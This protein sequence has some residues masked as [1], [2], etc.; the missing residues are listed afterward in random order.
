MD[1][2]VRAATSGDLRFDIDG[3]LAGYLAAAAAFGAVLARDA[4]AVV[5]AHTTDIPI[6]INGE[7]NIDF[8]GDGQVDFQIDHDRYNLGGTDLDYLQIDKN[9]AS[10]AED[11]LPE[12]FNWTFPKIPHPDYNEN[13]Q[14]DAADYTKW[15]NNLGVVYDPNDS[16]QSAAH[17]EDGNGNGVIDEGD[18][19]LWKDAFGSDPNYDHQYMIP[20]GCPTGNGCYPA[21]LT[22][23]STIGPGVSGSQWDFSESTNAF[24]SG[25][26]LRANRL[27]DEDAGQIDDAIGGGSTPAGDSPHFTG[28]AGA[29]RF[30]GVRIDLNDA[31]QPGNL[32]PTENGSPFK[33]W[34]GWIGVQITNEAD[35]TG[36]ITGYAYESIVGVGITAG[37]TGAGAGSGAAV[38][39]PS[40][41]FLGVIGGIFML[42]AFLAR[43]LLGGDKK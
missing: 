36:I 27:I 40:S 6:G 43:K 12:A 22:T 23:G 37:N 17:R 19:A 38:P 13:G 30:I 29:E 10:S 34:Y 4:H 5:V 1:D 7:A 20:A 11:P 32:L 33:Y 35:A 2:R 9:D 8:N 3:K 39:E 18:Y 16:L 14:Y 28:L 42:G 41:I 21:A 26:A 25:L 24:G 15:R 31:A